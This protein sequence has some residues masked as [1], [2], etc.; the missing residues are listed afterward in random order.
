MKL[1]KPKV[2]EIGLKSMKNLIRAREEF[3]GKRVSFD[4]VILKEKK[5][6]DKKIGHSEDEFDFRIRL[7]SRKEFL[8]MANDY[9]IFFYFR[10][11]DFDEELDGN[12][13]GCETKRHYTMYIDRINRYVKDEDEG[14]LGD[15]VVIY[16][17]REK[18]GE[19]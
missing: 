3:V 6:K 2:M 16:F 18:P 19:Y 17:S 10:F 7:F 12:F 15:E 5:D 8:A 14:D 11:S 9:G 1:E 13:E 4:A